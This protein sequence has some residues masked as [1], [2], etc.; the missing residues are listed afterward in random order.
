MKSAISR[1]GTTFYIDDNVLYMEIG[2]KLC[3]NDDGKE[4]WQSHQVYLRELR[5]EEHGYGA[6]FTQAFDDYKLGIEREILFLSGIL[7]SLEKEEF[8][9][10]KVDWCGK[11]I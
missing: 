8:V 9:T 11:A 6:S 10:E 1:N 5:I 3:H 2:M 7:A 4:K